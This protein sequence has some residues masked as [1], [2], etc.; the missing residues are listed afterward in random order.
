MKIPTKWATFLQT[1]KMLE[2]H[3]EQ[4]FFLVKATTNGDLMV[5]HGIILYGVSSSLLMA[6]VRPSPSTNKSFDRSV[7]SAVKETG[8]MIAE[9]SLTPFSH[10]WQLLMHN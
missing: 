9:L 10:S 1:K 8:A 5:S 3:K 7:P 4:L 2:G 6:Q